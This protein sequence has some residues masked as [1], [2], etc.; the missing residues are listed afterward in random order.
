MAKAVFMDDPAFEL[1]LSNVSKWYPEVAEAALKAGA[2]VIADEMKRSLAG[3]LSANA[4]GKLLGAFGITPIRQSRD[5]NWNVHLGFDGYREPGHVAFLLVARSFES[6]AVIGGR[7]KKKKSEYEYWRQPT[8]FATNAVKAKKSE[9]QA[10][11]KKTAEQLM[12]DIRQL[13]G[14]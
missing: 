1:A 4:T 12:V 11:M 6:G 9:A 10:L 13:G 5:G 14:R 2:G 3:K 7:A 8:R